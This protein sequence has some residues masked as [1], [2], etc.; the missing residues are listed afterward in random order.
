MIGD[1]YS[2]MGERVNVSMQQANL[3]NPPVRTV[4]EPHAVALVERAKEEQQETRSCVTRKGA[5]EEKLRRVTVKTK[6]GL[7]IIVSYYAYTL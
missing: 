5:G 2:L 6:E 7:F 1:N 4:G 3:D